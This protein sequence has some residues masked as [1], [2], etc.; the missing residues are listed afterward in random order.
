[1]SK[2]SAAK[3]R[4]NTHW[5]WVKKARSHNVR[6]GQ[7]WRHSRRQVWRCFPCLDEATYNQ[8]MWKW[9]YPVTSSIW[10]ILFTC[11][12]WGRIYTVQVTQFRFPPPNVAQFEYDPQKCKQVWFQASFMCGNKSAMIVHLRLLCKLTDRI[13]PHQCE[14]YI[15]KLTWF[16]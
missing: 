12:L 16:F 1:M 10:Q 8:M 7:Q 3:N 15:E 5:V 6:V 14:S 9:F 13:F 4:P 2:H 11:R